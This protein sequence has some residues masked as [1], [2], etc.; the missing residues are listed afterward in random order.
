MTVDRQ[1]YNY[2]ESLEPQ[3]GTI[4]KYDA[5][6]SHKKAWSYLLRDTKPGEM[7]MA[8]RG[9][10]VIIAAGYVSVLV[11]ILGALFCDILTLS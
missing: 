8:I 9:K 7:H 3:V 1:L 6:R 5:K 2:N 11:P 10:M 4:N